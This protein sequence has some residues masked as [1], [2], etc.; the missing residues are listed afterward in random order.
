MENSK[1]VNRATPDQQHVW[2]VVHAVCVTFYK[3]GGPE[4]AADCPRAEQEASDAFCV[5]HGLAHAWA[6]TLGM[7]AWPDCQLGDGLNALLQAGFIVELRGR[8]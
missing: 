2:T 1:P 7:D 4:A 3:L 8:E 5:L 6:E